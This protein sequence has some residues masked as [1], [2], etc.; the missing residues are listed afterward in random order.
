MK[1]F[2]VSDKRS[3]SKTL[4]WQVLVRYR[5]KGGNNRL[6]NGEHFV[7]TVLLGCNDQSIN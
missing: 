2:G 1:S 3:I 5:M 4:L 7:E 6:I